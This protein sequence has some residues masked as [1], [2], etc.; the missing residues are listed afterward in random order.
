MIVILV[1]IIGML[2]GDMGPG[3]Q[4]EEELKSEY[5]QKMGLL[6]KAELKVI[7]KKRRPDTRSQTTPTN[8]RVHTCFARA[9]VISD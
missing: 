9:A 4:A 8:P 3:L 2:K 6:R 7:K 1:V 5:T